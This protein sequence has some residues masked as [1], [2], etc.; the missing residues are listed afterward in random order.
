MIHDVLAGNTIV[1]TLGCFGSRPSGDPLVMGK[2]PLGSA[3]LL[4][5]EV[6][7]ARGSNEN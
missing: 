2:G 5:R 4:D 3:E 1:K 7:I 6:A